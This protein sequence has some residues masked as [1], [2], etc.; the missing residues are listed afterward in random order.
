MPINPTS[1]PNASVPNAPTP[2]NSLDTL[3]FRAMAQAQYS[4]IGGA[5]SLWVPH[6]V[7]RANTTGSAAP[8]WYQLDVAGGTVAANTVQGTTWDPDGANTFHRYIPSLAVDRLGD[9]ALGYTTSNSTTNPI[10]S[11]AGRLAGDPV[12]TFSQGE[13][14]LIAGAGTQTGNCGASACARWGDYSGMALDPDG[15]EFWETAEYYA[16]NGLNH[17]TRI[18]SFRF[19]GARR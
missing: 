4:N 15:C 19:P 16:T 10:I 6:T 7:R 17:Q 14:T 9:M 12:N 5:E 8:R 11:Y 1:W 18:G 2:G 13:Q 3:P